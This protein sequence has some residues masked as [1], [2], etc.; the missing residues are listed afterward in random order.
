M[1]RPRQASYA[2]TLGAFRDGRLLEVV[3]GLRDDPSI[4]ARHL[5]A[6]TWL[7]LGDAERALEALEH[8]PLLDATFGAIAER[9]TLRA[10]ALGRLGRRDDVDELLDHA[11]VQ[12][13]SSG[14]AARTVEAYVYRAIDALGR[15]DFD[16]VEA[17]ASEA[18]T[19]GTSYVPMLHE[20]VMPYETCRARA[21][22]LIGLAHRSRSRYRDQIEPAQRACELAA[23]GP[24]RWIEAFAIANLAVALR[25]V[26]D[27]GAVAIGRRLS[28]RALAFAWTDE[29]G[30]RRHI[31]YD[32][33]G[34]LAAM[35]GDNLGA[36]AWYRRAREAAVCP[37]E[38]LDA[39][40]SRAALA[41]ELNQEVLAAEELALAI[42]LADR[43]DW[44]QSP[45]AFRV[46]LLHLALAAA[47]S[48]PTVALAALEQY[49][50][51][52]SYSGALTTVQH[53]KS[54]FA[55]ERL[56]A[57][58]T[59]RHASDMLAAIAHL[60]AALEIWDAIGW[61]TWGTQTAIELV[62]LGCEQFRKRAIAGAE[63][64]PGSW[65]ARRVTRWG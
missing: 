7:R 19:I 14:S 35:R 54:T 6:R 38:R 12:A 45:N 53:E 47:P 57:G 51:L 3:D 31:A 50:A 49:R 43:I 40:L 36:F 25:D 52:T 28:A 2:T 56:A 4:E 17:E 32:A 34:T 63:R 24:D 22:E 64:M 60:T 42:E 58:V 39:H 21:Y 41:H 59:E 33:L 55:L 13:L 20:S 62:E 1:L 18:L 11:V 16:A 61:R 46:V 8:A 10:A 44:T 15:G 30:T 37:E 48:C 29:M 9:T 5:L 26:A 65:M 23:E 27:D